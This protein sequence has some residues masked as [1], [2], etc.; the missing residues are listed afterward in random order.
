[1]HISEFHYDLPQ[2]AIAQEA[3]EPRHGARLLDTRD[4]S[5]HRFLDLPEMLDPEDLLVVNETRVRAARLIGTRVGT[6]GR[7]EL[8]LIDHRPD[9]RWEAVARPARRL[10]TGVEIEFGDVTATVVSEPRQGL[11]LVDIHADDPE[12]VIERIGTVPLPPYFKGSLSDPSRYQ[13]VFARTTGSS[14]AP[15]AGLHFTP[16]VLARLA[17]RGIGIA[18]ID[19]HV[20]VDSFRPITVERL[21]DHEMHAE[22]CS[23]PETTARRISDTRARGGRVV[24]VGTTVVRTLESFS[25]GKGGVYPGE[26]ETR[27]F[28]RPGS[29]FGVVDALVTNFHMPFST[30]LVMVAGFM[31]SRWRVAYQT[32]LQ[33]GYRF[34]SFGDA[35]YAEREGT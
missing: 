1:M 6:G 10:R 3:V 7:I 29:P 2:D 12:A 13:T 9:G 11:V 31:G 30:L 21:E 15:T 20:S 32:A 28:L 26:R 35:M 19:L 5:D 23:V 22:R 17:E 33:R 27:L 16:E 24:A 25:D 8:L 4:L 14:A 18:P 34:L